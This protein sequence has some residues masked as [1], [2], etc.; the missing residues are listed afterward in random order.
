MERKKKKRMISVSYLKVTNELLL[1]YWCVQTIIQIMYK[2]FACYMYFVYCPG[3]C[4]SG[5]TCVYI[6]I[7][8]NKIFCQ[9]SLREK[10]FKNVF[11]FGI[12]MVMWP[13][14]GIDALKWKLL[15]CVFVG[16]RAWHHIYFSFQGTLWNYHN[17]KIPACTLSKGENQ[18]FLSA[19]LILAFKGRVIDWFWTT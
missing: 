10:S 18:L 7:F 14:L 5:C 11:R 8:W 17:R 6:Y 4:T 19:F 3:I 9:N 2:Q 12:V 1:G 15:I 13:C 16:K